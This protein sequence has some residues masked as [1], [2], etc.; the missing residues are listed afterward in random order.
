MMH[1]AERYIDDV[2]ND[3]VVAGHWVRQACQRQ[4][5]DLQHGPERGLWF[6]QAAAEK[7]LSFFTILKHSKGK[8]AGQPLELEPWQ[9]F[10]LWVVFGWKRSDGTRRFRT[11][12]LEVARK[13]GKST[14][15][16]GIG[17]YLLTADGEDGAEIYSAATKKDQAKITWSEAA[18]MVRKSPRLV[19]RLEV[20]GDRNPKASACNISMPSTNSKFEPIGRDT[21]SLDGPN[22]HGAIIDEVHAHKTREMWDLLET[23]TGARQQ[24]LLFAITTA[25]F[26]RNSLCWTLNEFT[27]KILDQVLPPEVG[28]DFFGL[29]YTLDQD[30]DWQDESVWIK[31][32]PNL[33][34]SKKI[35]DLRR[36]CARAMEIPSSQN[37]FKRLEVDLW[38]QSETKWVPWDHWGK[39]GHTIDWDHL[40]GRACYSGLD[41]SSTLDITAHVLVFPP[42]TE[43]DRYII[44]PRFWIPE[45]NMRRRAHDDRVPYDVWVQQ[46][47]IVA[48]SGNVIDYDFIFKDI[49]ADLK[50]YR[51]VETAF[52]RWGASR[53]TTVLQNDLGY[54][55][56]QATHKQTSAPLLVDFGQGFASMSPPMKELE[57]L[58]IS[59]GI[60][61]GNNPVLS[62]MADNLVANVDP[63][64]N[65]KPDKERS[66]EKIDG[67][68]ALI[69]AL[70]RSMR[71]SNVR[72]Q[73]IYETRGLSRI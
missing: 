45:E 29:I 55:T 50:V 5:D 67:M 51:L 2:L 64:G 36:K 65:I 8:W 54:T 44:L 60:E 7:V 26:D 40:R 68:V 28:D 11:S 24:P 47:W 13:N 9:Q 46:G 39:C 70:D 33:G 12:Y 4:L 56:D 35:E 27:K 14:L 43:H 17:L 30:D 22:V 62:W 41:L 69:M 59:H 38:T 21:D 71:N 57:R 31:A 6:D 23:A 73:S 34:V 1:P 32:N 10:I 25:G 66:R 18:R 48:T 61:H 63:A 49:E 53:V 42:E 15:A 3:R 52:D 19:K 72:R 58:I 20:Y 37:A 16:A